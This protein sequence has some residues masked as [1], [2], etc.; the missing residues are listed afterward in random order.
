MTAIPFPLVTYYL[1]RSVGSPIKLAFH[2]AAF[3]T[4]LV[5]RRHS[6]GFVFVELEV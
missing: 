4:C 3:L 2:V 5:C 1:P 6:A